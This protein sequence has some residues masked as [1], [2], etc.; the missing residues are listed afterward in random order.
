MH[1]SADPTDCGNWRE[2]RP[3]TVDW[4]GSA[5]AGAGCRKHYYYYGERRPS[6]A[7]RDFLSVQHFHVRAIPGGHGLML[8]APDS[9]H[10]AILQDLSEPAAW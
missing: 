3:S 6:G 10:R 7:A 9:L 8:E 5:F 4:A 2:R 1:N